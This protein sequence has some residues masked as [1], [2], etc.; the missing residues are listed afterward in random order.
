MRTTTAAVL[1][2]LWGC[3][4]SLDGEID[5]LRAEIVDIERKVPAEAPLWIFDG[6]DRFDQWVDD[7]SPRVPD[8]LYLHLVRKLHAMDVREMDAQAGAFD[9]EAAIQDPGRYRGR[10][11]RIEGLVAELHAEP[12]RDPKSPVTMVHAGVFF[13]P[14]R[15]PVLFHVVQ[16]PDVLRLREDTVETTALFLKNVEYLSRSGRRVTAPLFI[17][18]LLRRTL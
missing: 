18:K 5:G 6:P 9:P 17:G 8:F 13:D 2:L 16:K 7:R 4:Y 1:G 15:R 14:A 3:S 12:I 10:F 11:W